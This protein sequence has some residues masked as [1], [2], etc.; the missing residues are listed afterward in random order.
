MAKEPMKQVALSDFLTD[1]EIQQAIRL[2]T[3]KEIESKIISPNIDRINKA[4]KQEND[5]RYLAY[6]VSFAISQVKL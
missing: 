5:P 1:K 6:A 4:L 3:A 2:K